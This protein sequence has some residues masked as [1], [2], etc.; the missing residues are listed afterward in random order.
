M[1]VIRFPGTN[2]G[3]LDVVHVLRNVV[4]VDAELVWHE[5]FRHG[6]YDAVVV[7]GGFS[8]GGDWLRAGAIAARSRAM[9]EVV[10]D[11]EGGGVPVLGICNGFQILVEAGLLLGRCYPM[12]HPGS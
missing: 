9:K 10:M 2:G 6:I 8:Y 11:A 5:D 3:D 7:P 12:T 1:A 4:R